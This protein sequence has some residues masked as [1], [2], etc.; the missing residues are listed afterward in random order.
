[1]RVSAEGACHAL[2]NRKTFSFSGTHFCYRLSKLQDLV[3]PEGLGKLKKCSDIITFDF[4]AWCLNQRRYCVQLLCFVLYF[5]F[6]YFER[7][8]MMVELFTSSGEGG[9]TPTLL[10]PIERANQ[11]R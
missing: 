5:M 3:Q 9:E 4:V 6:E 8:V 2:L 10:G 1:V 7:A 11:V